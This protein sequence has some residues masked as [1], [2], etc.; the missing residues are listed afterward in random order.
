[1]AETEYF[2]ADNTNTGTDF[3]VAL[4]TQPE[5]P[6]PN[7]MES[8][9]ADADGSATTRSITKQRRSRLKSGRSTKSVLEETLLRPPAAAMG[10]GTED[11]SNA[12]HGPPPPP[13]DH[14][15]V[16]EV[17]AAKKQ[18]DLLRDKGGNVK[19]ITTVLRDLSGRDDIDYRVLLATG[20]GKTVNKLTTHKSAKVSELAL[21]LLQM[22]RLIDESTP[23][24]EKALINREVKL[25]KAKPAPQPQRVTPESNEAVDLTDSPQ[26]KSKDADK[27]R[28]RESMIHEDDGDAVEVVSSS[29]ASCA[30][31]H[32]KVDASKSKENNAAPKSQ[33]R[34]KKKATSETTTVDAETNN[35]K[36]MPE[37]PSEQEVISSV[38]DEAPGKAETPSISAQTSTN[39]VST[40]PKPPETKAT[41]AEAA[42]PTI[43]KRKKRT[44]HDQ[45]L[46]TMLTSSKPY[47]LKTL[48]K[49]CD[50]TV[51]ALRHAMLS[52]VDKKLVICKEFP[53][54][55]AN[56]EPKKL[57]WATQV[58][59]S[60][61]EGGGKGKNGGAVT[62]ELTKLLV[63]AEDI[64]KARSELSQLVHRYHGV[65]NELQP[66]LDVPSNQQLDEGMAVDE[67]TLGR[68]RG[69][70]R[71]I[72]DRISSTS[73]APAPS[74]HGAGRFQKPP[75]ARPRNPIALKRNINGML[76]E[77][78]SRK[79]KCMDFVENL[80]DAMEKK[81]KDVT[82]EKVLCLE[83]DEEVWGQWTDGA[84]GKTYGK[85][86]PV[87]KGLGLLGRRKDHESP[88]AAAVKLPAKYNDV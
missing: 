48:A 1:M 46:Y 57:Y 69:E 73:S 85:P 68:I 19:K 8:P 40:K 70:I 83:T 31:V 50:T 7:T 33:K 42:V 64:E 88:P 49:D 51:E 14:A 71:A 20:I 22:W 78:K 61:S 34:K 38:A 12:K 58:T 18:L 3:D 24:E 35:V 79:R 60:E 2:A 41:P 86:K 53:S 84:T 44:F 17:G 11:D 27:P 81:V 77:F 65:Q 15:N 5:S 4:L 30:H 25:G 75:A 9:L 66:M 36:E 28:P 6:L 72:N 82:G 47:T 13:F 67:E 52:F 32:D 26:G 10:P 74:S 59:L 87:K 29:A 56:R 62:K 76:G 37:A 39:K 21:P 45:I 16:A 23:K 63:P 80:A 54:K 55:N 43:K